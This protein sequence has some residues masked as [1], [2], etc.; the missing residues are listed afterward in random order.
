MCIRDR[1]E[2]RISRARAD[3]DDVACG[4][5]RREQGKELS[6][7]GR[8]L[9]KTLHARRAVVAVLRVAGF[10][11]FHAFQHGGWDGVEHGLNPFDKT[12]RVCETLKVSILT[13]VATLEV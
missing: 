9:P 1:P 6:R 2:S 10:E 11:V 12:F 5:A 13:Q 4:R 8:D 3:F 7:F